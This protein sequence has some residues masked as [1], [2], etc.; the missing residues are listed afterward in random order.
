MRRS[1]FGCRGELT[2]GVGGY[3][4]DLFG[5]RLFGGRLF[6]RS[7]AGG[8]LFRRRLFRGGMLFGRLCR[9]RF[10]RGF[11]GGLFRGRFTGGRLLGR[12]LGGLLGRVF[13]LR[14][15]GGR[16]RGR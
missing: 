9:C 6:R 15:G 1:I 10:L 13:P 7:L 2:I 3:R 8:R 12:R 4:S 11:G 5:R 16:V 14:G